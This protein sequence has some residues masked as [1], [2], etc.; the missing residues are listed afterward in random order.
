MQCLFNLVNKNFMY[1]LTTEWIWLTFR[2]L[3]VI[4]PT[5]LHTHNSSR[6]MKG[7]KSSSNLEQQK[8]QCLI[9][10]YLQ[11]HWK[12][13]KNNS[14]RPWNLLTPFKSVY[15]YSIC[16]KQQADGAFGLREN[17]EKYNKSIKPK[18]CSCIKTCWFLCQFSYW[19]RNTFKIKT[20]SGVMVDVD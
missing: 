2:N 4:Y 17:A 3:G 6:C 9:F 14:S 15:M 8:L 19:C 13:P 12:N 1:F 10:I 16:P 7:P 11:P 18:G 5:V 20:L